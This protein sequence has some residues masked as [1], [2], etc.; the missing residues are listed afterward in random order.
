MRR[1]CQTINHVDK[2]LCLDRYMNKW[3]MMGKGRK[4]A[5]TDNQWVSNTYT[6]AHLESQRL[7]FSLWKFYGSKHDFIYYPFRNVYVTNNHGNVP[8]VLSTSRFFLHSW[9]II[10]F[11]WRVT[12]MMLL[13]EHMSSPQVCS[14][15]SVAQS[16]VFCA[17]FCR[18]LFVP[19]ALFFIFYCIV[20]PS[21]IYSFWLYLL[22]LSL[23]AKIGNLESIFLFKTLFLQH[24]TYSIIF[25]L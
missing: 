3:N 17:V 5:L 2:R 19:F 16:L 10:G 14:W 1:T 24:K 9:L 12:S 13:V 18:S 25:D 4:V 6:I 20:C 11:V 23:C 8:S 7:I 21:L 22:D 15:I